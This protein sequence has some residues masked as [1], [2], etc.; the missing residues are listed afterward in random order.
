MSKTV[1]LELLPGIETAIPANINY[2]Q[3]DRTCSIEYYIGEVRPEKLHYLPAG[4]DLS[5]PINVSMYVISNYAT[6]LV[7]SK[8][9]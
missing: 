3:L 9:E 7:L 8:V 1:N 4:S 6:T 5:K 2:L